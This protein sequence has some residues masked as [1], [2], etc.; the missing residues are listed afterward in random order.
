[1]R[2]LMITAVAFLAAHG[3]QPQTPEALEAEAADERLRILLE[4]NDRVRATLQPVVQ[5][6][7]AVVAATD[8]GER[9]A[10]AAEFAGRLK[11]FRV[12]L[13]AS[14]A[15][16]N[17]LGTFADTPTTPGL[18]AVVR[19]Q[20]AAAV[21]RLSMTAE[22]ASRLEPL[23]AAAAAGDLVGAEREANALGRASIVML[24]AVADQSRLR[25]LLT[26]ELPWVAPM[27]RA[28]AEMIDA[29]ASVMELLAGGASRADASAALA[30]NA[31][32]IRELVVAAAQAIVMADDELS[33]AVLSEIKPQL[34]ERQVLLRQAAD[35][36]DEVARSADRSDIQARLVTL[37]S[38]YRRFIESQQESLR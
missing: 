32:R 26:P 33:A 24:R 21:S 3:A 37:R 28:A 1:M 7:A 15:R 30:S 20:Q 2:R 9:E 35:E 14:A 17:E 23:V 18:A 19:E 38:I 8:A 13:D 12:A 4:T 10:R 25:G 36:I 29:V 6:A 27:D 31:Q 16:L 22:I 5:G 34:I 11:E